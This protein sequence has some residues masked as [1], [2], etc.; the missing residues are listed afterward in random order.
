M[1]EFIMFMTVVLVIAYVGTAI[2]AIV[3]SD[4][5]GKGIGTTV[6]F[7]IGGCVA[8]QIATFLATVL[9]WGVIVVIVLAIVCVLFSS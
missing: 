8:I 1:E 7:S 6:A 4:S 2:F 9:C 5:I 3:T